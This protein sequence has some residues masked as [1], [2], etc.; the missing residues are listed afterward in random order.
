MPYDYHEKA[1]NSINMIKH[2]NNFFSSAR[3]ISIDNR[4]SVQVEGQFVVK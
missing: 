4:V 3:P 1:R 2:F